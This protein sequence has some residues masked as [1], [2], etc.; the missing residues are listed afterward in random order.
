[1]EIRFTK[2]HCVLSTCELAVQTCFLEVIDKSAIFCNTSLLRLPT[3]E[4]NEEEIRVCAMNDSMKFKEPPTLRV[5]TKE[6]KR[7]VS[8]FLIKLI[9]CQF[10]FAK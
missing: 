1:M 6:E 5:C 3:E 4:R 2:V 8:Q 9:H 10:F 7:I